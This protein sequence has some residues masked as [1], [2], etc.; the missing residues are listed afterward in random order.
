MRDP[1]TIARMMLDAALTWLSARSRI[2]R[3]PQPRSAPTSTG[4]AMPLPAAPEAP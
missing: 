4:S 3:T 2:T 1:E